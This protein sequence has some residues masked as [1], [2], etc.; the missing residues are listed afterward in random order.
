MQK[1]LT[2]FFFSL[3]KRHIIQFS[4]AAHITPWV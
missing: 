3:A 4:Q 1:K 2:S